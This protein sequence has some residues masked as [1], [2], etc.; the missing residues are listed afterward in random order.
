MCKCYEGDNGE[1]KDMWLSYGEDYLNRFGR[2]TKEINVDVGDVRYY[3]FV[4]TDNIDEST[5]TFESC[6]GTKI[7]QIPGFFSGERAEIEESF[8]EDGVFQFLSDLENEAD[9]CSSICVPE[10]FYMTKDISLGTPKQECLGGKLQDSKNISQQYSKW[11][12]I[13]GILIYTSIVWCLPLFTGYEK[14]AWDEEESELEMGSVKKPKIAD[15]Q[16]EETDDDEAEVEHIGDQVAQNPL[17]QS[18]VIQK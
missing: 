2:T 7:S 10:L 13:G 12:K 1:I 14:D 5:N 18:D 9:D 15:P 16:K 3:P 11:L 6:Y 17:D 8:F 4:W